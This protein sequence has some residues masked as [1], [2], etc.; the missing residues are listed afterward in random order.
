LAAKGSKGQPEAILAGLHRPGRPEQLDQD[1]AGMG[2]PS[3]VSQ[4]GEQKPGHPRLEARDHLIAT[5][6]SYTAEQL[7]SPDRVHSTRAASTNS[8]SA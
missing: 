4:V 2:A 3:V 6:N 5:D 1:I 8:H 7:N